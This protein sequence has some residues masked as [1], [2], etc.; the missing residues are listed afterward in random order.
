MLVCL[1]TGEVRGSAGVADSLVWESEW[2]KGK[3]EAC[4]RNAAE[5]SANDLRW[6]C[7]H[8]ALSQ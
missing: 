4:R 7:E 5:L 6:K 8:P 3:R 1:Q 2:D